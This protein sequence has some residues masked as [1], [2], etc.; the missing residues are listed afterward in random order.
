MPHKPVEQGTI[1]YVRIQGCY[2]K[3][4]LPLT[5]PHIL[6]YINITFSTK[7]S[8]FIVKSLAMYLFADHCSRYFVESGA[9]AYSIVLDC[10]PHAHW[11]C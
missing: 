5:M 9:Q 4:P 7:V 2:L 3:R 10:I 6:L 11:L 1:A 8:N